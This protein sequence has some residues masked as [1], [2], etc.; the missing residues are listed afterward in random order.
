MED[1]R[2]AVDVLKAALVREPEHEKAKELLQHLST[3]QNA[4]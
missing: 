4:Q 2:K 1:S 3:L